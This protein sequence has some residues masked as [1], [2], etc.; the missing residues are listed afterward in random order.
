MSRQC[1]GEDEVDFKCFCGS[2][3]K[4]EVKGFLVSQSEISLGFKRA[5]NLS[6]GSSLCFVSKHL[7]TQVC[8]ETGMT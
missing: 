4:G 8:G 1:P 3:G 6:F 5:R 7:L 2:E